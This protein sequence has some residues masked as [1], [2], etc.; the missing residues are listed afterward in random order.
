MKRK[1]LGIFL[2]F[3]TAQILFL[4]QPL[5]SAYET[6]IKILY[7]TEHSFVSFS[8][9]NEFMENLK[10]NHNIK[11]FFAN[12]KLTLDVL[13]RYDIL[14]IATP[15]EIFSKEERYCIKKFV[16]EGGNLLLMGNGWY[17]RH[18]HEKPLAEFPFNRLGKEF[19]V[20]INDDIIV[21]P[22]NYR[23]SRYYPIFHE[24][25]ENHPITEN[26]KEIWTKN[27]CSLNLE[28]DAIPVV[29]GDN[30]SY[31]G[32]IYSHPYKAGEY[33]PVVAALEYGKGRGIFIGADSFFDNTN[34]SNEDNLKFGLNIFSWLTGNK[35]T[36]S[37]SSTPSYAIVYIKNEYKGVT[38]LKL[39][40]NP[41]E[42]NIR[43]EKEGYQ[44]YA[45]TVELSPGGSKSISIN[46]N[47]KKAYLQIQ[48][49]RYM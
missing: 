48:M 30:D 2:I 42:Y 38:P 13:Y 22:T 5:V 1:I 14:V 17:W 40:M 9:C 36:L 10:E 18:Y 12:E 7:D 41:G 20:T 25:A 34:V 33:P 4:E 26:I 32:N 31:S 44:S 27:P 28:G 24:F 49:H 21:D 8:S 39:K 16:E 35:A 6:E 37:I 3:S 43:I 47:L 29:W 46:L 45:Q 23:D 19:G 15:I 11:I